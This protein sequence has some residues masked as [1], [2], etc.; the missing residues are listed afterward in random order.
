VIRGSLQRY[1]FCIHILKD[2]KA[3]V[4]VIEKEG[5]PDTSIVE[6]AVV[7]DAGLIVMGCKGCKRGKPLFWGA[8]RGLL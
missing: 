3:K 4:S 7:P 6:S 5:Y 2:V 1:Q 8:L